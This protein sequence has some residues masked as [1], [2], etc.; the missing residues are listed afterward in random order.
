MPDTESV[1]AKKRKMDQELSSSSGSGN[2]GSILGQVM[3]E[4]G[5][6]EAETPNKLERILLKKQTGGEWP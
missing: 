1:G 3:Q 6:I 4:L 2:Q 5:D